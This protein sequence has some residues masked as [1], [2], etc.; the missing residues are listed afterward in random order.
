MVPSRSRYVIIDT[1]MLL[2]L[3]EQTFDLEGAILRTVGRYEIIIPKAV[4]QELKVLST[5]GKGATKRW[6]KAALT[7]IKK[8]GFR[9]EDED[10]E[11]VDNSLITLAKKLNGV[12]ATNDKELKKRLREKGI[13]TLF[14]RERKRL[15]LLGSL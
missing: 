7:Y 5:A 10:N 12:V 3:F 11:E 9:I 8:K 4:V 15:M 1:N 13:P 14:L 2:T 6:A